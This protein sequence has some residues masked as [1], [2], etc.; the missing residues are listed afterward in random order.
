MLDTKILPSEAH[1]IKAILDVNG[2]GNVSRQELTSAIND[3][4]RYQA[5]VRRRCL[6]PPSAGADV[7]TIRITSYYYYY[8]YYQQRQWRSVGD[9]R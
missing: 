4:Q 6:R 2:D 8:Y 9:L 7:L 5:E 1:S 3:M